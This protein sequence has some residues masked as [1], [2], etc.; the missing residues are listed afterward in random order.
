MKG[1][2][3][4]ALALGL[5][6]AGAAAVAAALLTVGGPGTARLERLDER[7]ARDLGELAAAVER[8]RVFT[9]RLPASLDEVRDGPSGS[10]PIHDPETGAPYEYEV[11]GEGRFRVCARLSLP[12]APPPGPDPLRIPDSSRV[13][14]TMMD[15]EGGRLCR[16]TVE[17]PG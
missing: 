2:P 15:A 3:R 4:I 14:G 16:E 9:G 13:A 7:R 11:L 10:P 1:P 5:A 12:E 6:A 8:H 17:P